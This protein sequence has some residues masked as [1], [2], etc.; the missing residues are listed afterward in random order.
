MMSDFSKKNL[1]TEYS[2]FSEK[3]LI[4]VN[5]ML[6]GVLVSSFL[7]SWSLFCPF[8]QTIPIISSKTHI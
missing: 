1:I 2:I 7:I 3:Y 4:L 5:L 8:A 6:L